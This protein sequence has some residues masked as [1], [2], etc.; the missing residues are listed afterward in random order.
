MEGMMPLQLPGGWN[1]DLT[2]DKH[3][4]SLKLLNEHGRMVEGFYSMIALERIGSRADYTEAD[5]HKNRDAVALKILPAIV[6]DLSQACDLL[7]KPKPSRVELWD[8]LAM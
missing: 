6:A 1:R 5:I 4:I 7:P 2:W 8:Q 3:Q